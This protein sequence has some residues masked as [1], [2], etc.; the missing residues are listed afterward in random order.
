[1]SSYWPDHPRRLP[2]PLAFH[3]YSVFHADRLGESDL[4]PCQHVAEHRPGPRPAT[5]PAAPADANRLTPNCR[6]ALMVIRAAPAVTHN[7]HLQCT[8]QNVHLGNV[9]ARQQIVGKAD[10]QARQ[11]DR[12]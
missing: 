1:M 7:Q 11:I 5:A 4:N 2:A 6:T 3:D 9:L 12:G 8:L 10:T